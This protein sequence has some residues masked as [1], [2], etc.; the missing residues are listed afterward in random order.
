MRPEAHSRTGWP[1]TSLCVTGNSTF[2]PRRRCP[3]GFGRAAYGGPCPP[4]GHGPHRYSFKVYAVDVRSLPLAGEGQH[5][6]EV[7]LDRHTLA[8]AELMGRYERSR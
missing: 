5:D 4:R 7:A 6:L 8:I 1:T 2:T 3:T